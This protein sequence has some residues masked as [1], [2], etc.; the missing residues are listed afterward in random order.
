MLTKLNNLWKNYPSRFKYMHGRSSKILEHFSLDK[1]P[2]WNDFFFYWFLHFFSSFSLLAHFFF[3]L[4]HKKNVAWHLVFKNISLRRL[5]LR[6]SAALAQVMD[7]GIQNKL[8]VSWSH[9][10]MSQR[11]ANA[12]KLSGESGEASLGDLGVITGHKLRPMKWKWTYKILWFFQ[13]NNNHIEKYQI[14]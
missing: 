2:N 9:W 4:P 13:I 8:I 5:F 14:N 7:G 11:T 3:F 6:P 12:V 1:D 10:H